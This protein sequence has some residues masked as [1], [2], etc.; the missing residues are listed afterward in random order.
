MTNTPTGQVKYPNSTGILVTS[1][2]HGVWVHV[3]RLVLKI[4]INGKV[5]P[6]DLLSAFLK[7]EQWFVSTVRLFIFPQN[8]SV[9]LPGVSH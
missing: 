8:S 5:L 2:T 1:L 3:Q 9:C 4:K 7:E 6:G